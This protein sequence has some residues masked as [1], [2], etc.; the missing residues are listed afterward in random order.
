MV[1][2]LESTAKYLY[3]KHQ[4]EIQ[5][6]CFV[7]PNKRAGIFFS[8]YLA[9][10]AATTMWA[11][12]TRSINELMT[13]ISGLHIA[14]S[15]T[16]VFHLYQEY[17]KHR[18]TSETFDEFYYWGEMILNDFDD[19]DKYLAD[20]RQ[21]FQN[22]SDLKDID[23]LF[24][25]PEEQIE[26]IR[27]F[28]TNIKINEPSDL[29]TDFI[30]IW[31]VLH[32]IYL[33]YR[34]SLRNKNIAY[35][36]MMYRSV[37]EL[38][39]VNHEHQ[40]PYKRFA[41]VGFNALNKCE[42]EFFKHLKKTETVDF[43]WDYD[44]YYASH[45]NSWHEAGLFL[46]ENI[47]QFPAPIDFKFETDLI[48]NKNLDI[49]SFP[50]NTAQCKS[51]AHIL[52]NWQPNVEDMTNTAIVLADESL[53]LPV[54]SS[55]PEIYGEVNVSLGYPFKSTP[56]YSFIECLESLHRNIRKSSNHEI[57]FYHRDVLS[58]L[59]HP[60]TQIIC[61]EKANKLI[62]YITKFNRVYLSVTEFAE[63]D[64]LSV[65]F[66][67]IETAPEFIEY[68]L[69]IATL[70][71]QSLSKSDS[72]TNKGFHMEYWFSFVTSINRLKDIVLENNIMLDINTL[73][74]IIRKRTSTLVIPFK[75]EP[76]AGIQVMGILETRN[77]DFKNIIMLSVN[78]GVIPKSDASQSFIPY[79][80]RRGFD[81]PTPE[82]QDS[83]FAYYF[84]RSIQ[85]AN[86]VAFLYNTQIR[87]RTS[88]MSRFLYQMKYEPAF[89]VKEKGTSCKI[90]LSEEKDIII[91]KDDAI[92]QKLMQFTVSNDNHKTLTPTALNSWINCSLQFYF[93]YIA[94][95]REKEDV[96]ED[97][98]GSMFGKLLHFSMEEVYKKYIGQKLTDTDFK[99]IIANKS[100]IDECILKAFAVEYYRKENET[101]RLHGKSL[102]V[103]DVLRKYILRILEIDRRLSPI[104]MLE[105]EKEVKMTIPISTSNANYEIVIGGKID[106]IDCTSSTYR[107]ID[108]K[109]GKAEREFQSIE[110]LFESERY[111][112]NKEALQILLYASVLSYE[113]AYKTLPIS[114]GL[115]VMR[116]IF[117]SK[118]DSR[119]F[120][121]KKPVE[122]ILSL[123]DEFEM[124]LKQILSQ[125]FDSNISFYKT[126]NKK[127]CEYCDYIDICHR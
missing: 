78:E 65:I 9:K 124:N 15:L 37:V 36:G 121:E 94:N 120:S 106:R 76:L 34:E 42:K 104:T 35:E 89:Q 47:I 11:P 90:S 93:R 25:L 103:K 43:F 51:I 108:Y 105:F 118:F 38:F 111:K 27:E 73:I 79:N 69:N 74:K 100:F 88:E 33:S 41:I 115:Y 92:M 113:S 126:D 20:A 99:Q 117:E 68:L 84:Y 46:R 80:L 107:V 24:T 48:G 13:E 110:S 66:Q 1:P 44:F 70:T 21:V 55:L 12:N 85:R 28:W 57:R 40:F 26:I 91:E 39:K 102:V 86:N 61:N 29:K 49:I 14:D 30:S 109:T 10:H 16:L 116:E 56:A 101:P 2:F 77:L 72:D 87:N 8:K 63:I 53:L 127:A 96:T 6:I 52:E 3:E 45:E 31:K 83:I 19:I 75:G 23:S 95:I 32:D 114:T 82:H 17:I 18:K 60:Y 97:I 81:L 122:N 67:N 22:I 123:K 112:R 7:F 62:E 4:G 5:D 50:S 58:L 64:F 54:L 98:E 59:H 125:I 119:L 71:A